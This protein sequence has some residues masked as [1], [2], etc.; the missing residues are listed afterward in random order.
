MG[1]PSVVGV[2]CGYGRVRG[3]GRPGR[4][5]GGRWR[6]GDVSG[7]AGRGPGQ[8]R[9]GSSIG[10]GEP[11]QRPD[12][13]EPVD[14]VPHGVL[15]RRDQASARRHRCPRHSICGRPPAHSLRPTA[16][17]PT[18]APDRSRPPHHTTC[19]SSPLLPTCAPDCPQRRRAAHGLSPLIA[20]HHRGHD[21]LWDPESPLRPRPPTSPTTPI[22]HRDPRLRPRPLPA[23]TTAT[24]TLRRRD[25]PNHDS[26]HD[27]PDHRRG[28]AI[29]HAGRRSLDPRPDQDSAGDITDCGPPP[30]TTTGCHPPSR[31]ATGP[32]PGRRRQLCPLPE[33]P[34]PGEPPFRRTGAADPQSAIR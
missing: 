12:L 14:H 8:C 34:R 16:P 9:W 11:A 24:T 30:H 20:T 29:S 4:R 7:R 28:G 22:R 2:R 3:V 23:T 13:V 17:A 25:H 1:R 31:R 18:L 21:R 33:S 5:G 15:V 32:P 10:H 26:A 6:C 27:D 19:G